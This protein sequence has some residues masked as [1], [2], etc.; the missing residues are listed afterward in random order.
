MPHWIVLLAVAIVAWCVFSVGGGLVVGHLIRR[1]ESLR[2]AGS[3]VASTGR[4]SSGRRW[5]R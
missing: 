3:H 2:A 4:G 5:R 1:A